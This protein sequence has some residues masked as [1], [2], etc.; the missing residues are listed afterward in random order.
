MGK[1]SLNDIQK[2]M[3]RLH[4]ENDFNQKFQRNHLNLLKHLTIHQHLLEKTLQFKRWMSDMRKV[5]Q[6]YLKN[7]YS[8]C[9][10]KLWCFPWIII[11]F[12]KNC[13]NTKRYSLFKCHKLRE[14]LILLK[15]KLQLKEPRSCLMN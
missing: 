11:S 4:L 3:I 2:Q 15:E 8:L 10:Q 14:P 7:S 9:K 6:N 1:R 13:D 5:Q 12:E